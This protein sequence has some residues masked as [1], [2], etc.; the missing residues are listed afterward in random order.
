MA[1]ARWAVGPAAAYLVALEVADAADLS[2]GPDRFV[3]EVM[4]LGLAV[5][6][7]GFLVGILRTRLSYAEVGVLLPELT[8]GGVAPG[9]VRDVLARV[10][11][12]PSLELRYWSPS[13]DGYVD[14]TGHATDAGAGPGRAA[15][16]IDGDTGPLAVVV[17]DEAVLHEPGLVDAAGALV[18]LALENV[19]LQAEVRSQL[20]QLRSATVRLVQAGEDARR[21]LERDLHDGAQQRLLALAMNLD[22]ARSRLNGSTDPQVREF[23]DLSAADL[24]E[25]INELRELARGIHPML[26]TQEGL[27]SALHALADRAPLPVHVTAEAARYGPTVESTAYFLVSEAVTNAAR[28]ASAT[29]VDVSVRQQGPDLLVRVSDDGVGGAVVGG[30]SGLQGMKDRVV[31]AGGGLVMT[32]PV[33]S[34]TSIEARLPCA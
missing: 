12:D 14:A 33:G 10:L 34:G 22:R 32:S 6:P 23:L 27:G 21:R 4:P 31:A 5:L 3:H 29:R 25:A 13:A 16:R 2:G 15:R 17:V 11:H 19:R 1:P 26:L 20:V 28:H 8:A 9:R 24:Q 18:R 7:V 30:G